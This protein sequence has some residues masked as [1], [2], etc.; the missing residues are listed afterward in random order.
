MASESSGD[1]HKSHPTSS[2]MPSLTS[3]AIVAVNLASE[4]KNSLHGSTEMGRW[5]VRAALW[6]T[7]FW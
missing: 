6:L 7:M 2:L 5:P 4:E 1:G 3:A